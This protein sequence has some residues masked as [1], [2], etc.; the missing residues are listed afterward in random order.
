MQMRPHLMLGPKAGAE[1]VAHWQ[2]A[3]PTLVGTPP[4]DRT[5]LW[6]LSLAGQD[7]TL[8]IAPDEAG[9]GPTPTWSF[10]IDVDSPEDVDAPLEVL[11][12]GGQF[13][14]PPDAYEF[15][16]RFAWVEDRFGVSWQLRFGPLA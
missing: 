14:M 16:E 8:F 13:L 9:F 4:T 6:R 15:A 10:L 7:F 5:L 3:F 11:S 2:K 12:E 1:A